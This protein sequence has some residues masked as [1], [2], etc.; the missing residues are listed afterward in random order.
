MDAKPT[1]FEFSELKNSNSSRK[2]GRSKPKKA[3][4]ESPKGQDLNNQTSPVKTKLTGAKR[5]NIKFDEMEG[6][7]HR[8]PSQSPKS[9][10]KRTKRSSSPTGKKSR[11]SIAQT[12]KDK[13]N[14]ASLALNDPVNV[15]NVGNLSRSTRSRV[16]FEIA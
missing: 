10:N 1:Q 3:G 2:M 15:N 13:N 16:S 11:V 14:N 9:K 4:T 6:D 7:L 12:G 5:K 8:S